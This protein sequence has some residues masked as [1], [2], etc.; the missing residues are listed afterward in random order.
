MW[1]NDNQYSIA[2]DCLVTNLK[3]FIHVCKSRSSQI[4]KLRFLLIYMLST[5]STQAQRKFNSKSL[6]YLESIS[7]NVS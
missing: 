4:E 5:Q 3:L 1:D 7:S 6:Y 2:F